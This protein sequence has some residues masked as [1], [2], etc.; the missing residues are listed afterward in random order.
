MLTLSIQEVADWNCMVIA[1]FECCILEHVVAMSLWADA[2]VFL[3][4]SLCVSANVG[5]FLLMVNTWEIDRDSTK[6]TSCSER[7]TFLSFMECTAASAAETPSS[8][9]ART[10]FVFM[11]TMRNYSRAVIDRCEG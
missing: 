2:H 4:E 6:F 5:G 1:A 11:V 9:A 7:G 3:A 10:E 8:A